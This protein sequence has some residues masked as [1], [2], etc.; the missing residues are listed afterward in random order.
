MYAVCLLGRYIHE[1]IVHVHVC[2][3]IPVYPVDVQRVHDILCVAMLHVC[4]GELQELSGLSLASNPLCSPPASVVQRGTRA[5]LHYLRDQLARR[6]EEKERGKER[7]RGA[8]SWG[9]GDASSES[10]KY[11]CTQGC[12]VE[13][14]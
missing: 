1:Y 3:D 5:V 8:D 14:C 10:G 4:S 7:R 13:Y 2:H 11:W 9:D 12:L 6:K